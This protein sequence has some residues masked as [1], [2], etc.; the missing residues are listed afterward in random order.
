M[1]RK[2]NKFIAGEI[3]N[4]RG[5]VEEPHQE[6]KKEWRQCGSEAPIS[7]ST[8]SDVKCKTN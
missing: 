8:I 3:A 5:Q 4:E 6:S 2:E 1:V 7:I